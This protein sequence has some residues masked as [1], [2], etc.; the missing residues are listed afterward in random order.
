MKLLGTYQ[1]HGRVFARLA[2]DSEQVSLA[3][4][5]LFVTD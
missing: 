2:Y 5:Q 4:L 1:Q 3:V